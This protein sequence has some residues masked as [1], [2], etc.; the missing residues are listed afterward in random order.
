MR[1]V[2]GG[3][4][5]VGVQDLCSP[6]L[7]A[8]NLGYSFLRSQI[9]WGVFFGGREGVKTGHWNQR[10]HQNGVDNFPKWMVMTSSYLTHDE[11]YFGGLGPNQKPL[12]T[13]S[14]NSVI[15]CIYIYIYLI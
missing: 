5:E 2:F 12:I 1:Q 7:D 3:E 10:L 11:R 14:S 9:V 8:A 4:K 15:I 13:L 6:A